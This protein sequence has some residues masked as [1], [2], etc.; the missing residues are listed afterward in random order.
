MAGRSEAAPA[1]RPDV[2]KTQGTAT[3]RPECASCKREL[4]KEAGCLPFF[5]DDGGGGAGSKHEAFCPQ[6]FVYVRAL[7]EQN[8]FR[9]G[10]FAAVSCSKCRCSSVAVGELRCGGCG[11]TSGLIELPPAFGVA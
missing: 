4:G 6:C 7:R 11:N 8:R 5:C 1:A 3:S 10:M 9:P 2:A